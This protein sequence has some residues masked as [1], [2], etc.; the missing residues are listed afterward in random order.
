MKKIFFLILIFNFKFALSLD[1][2]STQRQGDD[3][4][5]DILKTAHLS[6]DEKKKLMEYKSEPK[7]DCKK[8][9]ADYQLLFV[10]CCLGSKFLMR[11]IFKK[12]CCCARR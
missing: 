7:Y 3:N 9:C 1:R 12:I 11:E 8:R 5:A 6:D 4:D 10:L 2:Q